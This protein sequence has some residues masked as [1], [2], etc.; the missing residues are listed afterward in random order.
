MLYAHMWKCTYCITIQ[1]NTIQPQIN[2]HT[3]IDLEFCLSSINSTFP[4]IYHRYQC[5]KKYSAEG[6]VYPS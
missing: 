4:H 2:R 5:N 6:K 1:Y 3:Y